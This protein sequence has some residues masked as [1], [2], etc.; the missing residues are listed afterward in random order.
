VEI[1]NADAPLI[2]EHEERVAYV[3]CVFK[4]KPD[5]LLIL[6]PNTSSL[7]RTQGHCPGG[8]MYNALDE[9]DDSKELFL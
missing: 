8:M 1:P 2:V 4:V 9:I 7:A 5:R 3:T 6:H